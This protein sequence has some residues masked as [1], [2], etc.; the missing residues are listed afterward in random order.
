MYF[1]PD[2]R[3]IFRP[4]RYRALDRSRHI[5]KIIGEETAGR[6]EAGLFRR[7]LGLVQR[8]FKIHQGVPGRIV[9]IC[10]IE[11]RAAQRI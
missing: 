5:L 11:A 2:D 7:R 6:D 9:D 8:H 10:Q 3:L 4:R 1:E